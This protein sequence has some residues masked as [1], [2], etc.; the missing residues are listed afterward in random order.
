MERRTLYM[1]IDNSIDYI[2]FYD[3]D[4]TILMVLPEDTEHPNIID[5]INKLYNAKTLGDGVEPWTKADEEI[6]FL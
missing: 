1:D 5:A 4:N 6:N 2:T 3:D